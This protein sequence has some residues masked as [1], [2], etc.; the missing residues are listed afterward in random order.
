MAEIDGTKYLYN[1]N[2]F[3]TKD[4]DEFSHPPYHN[5][6]I[7]EVIRL[8][9]SV[10]LFLEDYLNRLENSFGLNRLQIPYSRTE[11]KASIKK[12]AELNACTEG[13]VKLLFGNGNPRYFMLYMMK[14]HLPKP[15]EYQTGV[16]TIFLHETRLNPNAKNLNTSLRNRSEK[17]LA[18]ADAYESILV[19]EDGWITEGSRSNIFFTRGHEIFTTP[20]YLILPGITRKKVLKILN[21]SGLQITFAT[22]RP[23]DLPGFNS[24]FLTGTTRKIVPVRSIG[25]YNFSVK[26]PVLDQISKRFEEFVG[27][28]ISGSK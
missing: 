10:P 18:D 14:P 2:V 27:D 21:D 23:A 26:E 20:D 3:P 11:I 1:N 6:T 5:D 22:I 9:E 7:Y 4:M 17:M 28:Y 25:E 13:P 12:L 16:R 19:N 24:C 8:E 15:E